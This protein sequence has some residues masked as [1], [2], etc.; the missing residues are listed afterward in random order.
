MAKVEIIIRDDA[1]NVIDQRGPNDYQLDLGAESLHEIEGA[2][3][4]LKNGALPDIEATLLEAAQ[5]DFVA[6]KKRR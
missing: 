3:E 4:V 5:G 6:Q 2:V 1:G